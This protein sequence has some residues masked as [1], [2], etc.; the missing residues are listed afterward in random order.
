MRK[1]LFLLTV[2]ILAILTSAHGVEVTRELPQRVEKL[3]LFSVKISIQLDEKVESVILSE[4]IP[5]G[6]EVIDSSGGELS[7]GVLKWLFLNMPGFKKP[8][9]Q[10]IEY[11]LRAPKNSGYYSFNGVLKL[12][13]KSYDV[14]GDAILMVGCVEKWVCEEWSECKNGVQKRNCVD[15]NKCG[16]KSNLPITE[17]QCIDKKNESGEIL[18]GDGKKSS[19]GSKNSFSE[20]KGENKS[21]ESGFNWMLIVNLSLISLIAFAIVALAVLFVRLRKIESK[22]P[23]WKISIYR[24]FEKAH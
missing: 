6:F 13:N 1:A 24:K 8:E 2:F 21:R 19:E 20:D 15:L 16:T 11:K 14:L 10:I 7:N 17:K 9:S 12:P 22:M 3:E 18:N 23:E 4:A 5:E